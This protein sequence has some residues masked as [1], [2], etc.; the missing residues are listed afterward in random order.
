MNT[1]KFAS[2][3]W[4]VRV[5]VCI[6]IYIY[7]YIYMRVY[8]C[9]YICVYVYGPVLSFLMV[10]LKEGDN[11]SPWKSVSSIEF[12]DDCVYV[13]GSGSRITNIF[14]QSNFVFSS[15]SW[16]WQTER[17]QEVVYHL[18]VLSSRIDLVNK[19]LQTDD[20]ILSLRH[21]QKKPIQNIHFIKIFNCQYEN[22]RLPDTYTITE[23]QRIHFTSVHFK[24]LHKFPFSPKG[25]LPGST[26]PFF[27][28][29]I[30]KK[31]PCKS[32]L[33]KSFVRSP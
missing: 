9:V 5:C 21:K 6:Y 2:R 24:Y 20:P 17:T 28:I 8:M 26:A 27:K 22:E 23:Y 29:I 25:L 31:A 11:S 30:I 18:E 1:K 10:Y 14:Q 33:H 19:V 32:L 3:H 7:I 15:M 16:Y 13:L 4:R 12:P